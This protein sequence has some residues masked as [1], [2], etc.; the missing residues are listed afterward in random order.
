MEFVEA[1]EKVSECIDD[2]GDVM[3]N[4]IGRF[5]RVRPTVDDHLIRA[6]ANTS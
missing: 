3:F 5:I 1:N 6:D 4:D 2:H